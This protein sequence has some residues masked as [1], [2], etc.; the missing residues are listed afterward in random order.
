VGEARVPVASI[1]WEWVV[2][3]STTSTVVEHE[4]LVSLVTGDGDVLQVVSEEH[5]QGVRFDHRPGIST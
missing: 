5:V 3:R 2:A 1:E 4:P